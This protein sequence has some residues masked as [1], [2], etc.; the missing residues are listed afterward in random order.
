M[1]LPVT[2]GTAPWDVS[3]ILV[4]CAVSRCL[5]YPVRS[6]ENRV[7]LMVSDHLDISSK[8]ILQKRKYT[9]FEVWWGCIEPFEMA[10]SCP[11]VAV[12]VLSF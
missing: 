4:Y 12:C 6:L 7:P 1:A 8:D 5:G 10:G 2:V 11:H 9:G 3:R